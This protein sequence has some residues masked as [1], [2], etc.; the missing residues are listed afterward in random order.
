MIVLALDLATET[1]WAVDHE[2][3]SMPRTGSYELRGNAAS[4]GYAFLEFSKWLFSFARMTMADVIAYEAPV[5]GGMP[6]GPDHAMLLIGLA[7][8][9]EEKAAALDV[10]CVQTVSSTVRK[11]FLGH[12]RPDNPKKAVVD[13]CNLLRW[14]VKNNHNRA[15]AAALW[16]HTKAT[17]DP[18]FRVETGTALF[19]RAG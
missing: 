15:D 6:T 14:D 9:T 5:F 7:A 8:M 3:G 1:G 12:G 18:A 4:R 19:A 11:Y 16:C 13:R 17:L 10:R 2:G